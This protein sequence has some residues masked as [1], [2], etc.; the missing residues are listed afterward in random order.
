MKTKA[1]VLFKTGEPLKIVELEVP[2]LKPGQ[3]LVEV[4][5]SGVCHTQIL[6]TR[7]Y[8]GEDAYLPHCLGHEGSGKVLAIGE[9]VTRVKPGDDV[10]LSWM[11]ASGQN[12]PGTVY[13]YRGQPVNAGAITTFSKH[14]IISENRLTKL[15]EGASLKEA[16]L[17]GCAVAT[18][19]GAVMNVANAK[20]GESIAIFGVGGIGQCAL[21]A[22]V[23]TGCNPI[24]AIDTND[25]KLKLAKE[26]GA[27][28]A[29]NPKTEDAVNAIQKICSLD[30]AVEATG[31]PQ[32]M[33]QALQAVRN[34]GGRAVIIGNARDGE[35]LE[36]DP[37]QFN[38]GKKLLGTWGGDNNPD[39]HFP[40]Y[41][42]MLAEGKLSLAE[43]ITKTYKLEDI[44][45][46]LDDLEQGKV[47]RPL[48]DMQ[49]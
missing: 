9:S 8:R 32:A 26:Q 44:N 45:T 35:K 22:A 31:R 28:H 13:D 39:E 10:L 43:L 33:N 21:M 27:T 37:K 4:T 11:K 19:L 12:I 2:Q 24:I 30:I 16:A 14:S 36:I 5:Y 29:I 41:L 6:E 17:I 1:A 40:K 20:Q 18:G 47:L 7:G 3:V 25:D 34:Q 15:P 23:I 46:A 42:K 49:Q 38:M 48:I